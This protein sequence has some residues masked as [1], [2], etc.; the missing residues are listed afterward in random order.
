MANVGYKAEALAVRSEAACTAAWAGLFLVVP[1]A[2]PT[3]V[4]HA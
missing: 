3:N 2:V 4:T 1:R